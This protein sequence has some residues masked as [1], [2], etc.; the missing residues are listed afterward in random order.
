MKKI[1][2]EEFSKLQFTGSKQRKTNKGKS[3]VFYSEILGLH[4]GEN[5]FITKKEW[6]GYRTPTRICRYIMKKFPHVKYTFIKA[7]DKTGWAVKRVE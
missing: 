4:V 5:L 1:S 3:S 2:D 6:K 7:P